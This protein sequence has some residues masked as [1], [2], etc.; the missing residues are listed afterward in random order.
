MPPDTVLG[1]ESRAELTNLMHSYKRHFVYCA[2][3]SIRA[4]G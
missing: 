3:H 4:H 1:E 2:R